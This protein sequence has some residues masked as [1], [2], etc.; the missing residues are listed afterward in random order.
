MRF[1]ELFGPQTPTRKKPS[2]DSVPE[3]F[4]VESLDRKGKWAHEVIER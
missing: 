2:G 1:N 3:V 4:I